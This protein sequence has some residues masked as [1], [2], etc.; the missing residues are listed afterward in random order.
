MASTFKAGQVVQH[1][2]QKEWV[3]V[4][5]SNVMNGEIKSYVCRTKQF[6]RIKFYPFE[7]EPTRKNENGRQR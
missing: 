6:R 7:L 3:L 2:L 1:I 5:H 4:L